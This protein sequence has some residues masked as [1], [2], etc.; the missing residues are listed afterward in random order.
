MDEWL[1][2]IAPGDKLHKWFSHGLNKYEEFRKRYAKEVEDK[3]GIL[4]R[5]KIEEKKGTV[6]ILFSAK[7]T[8][9]NSATRHSIP[10]PLPSP[11][12]LR[13]GRHRREGR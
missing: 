9:H 8:E 4:A 1:K 7:D 13:A 2:E 6:T 10:L 3:S 12:R 11:K 5:I